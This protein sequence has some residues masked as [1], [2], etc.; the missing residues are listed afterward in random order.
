MKDLLVGSTGFVGENLKMAHKFGAFCHS[1]DVY[2]YYGMEPDLCV[3][4]GVPSAMY[5]AN[6]DPDADMAVIKQA[7][8]NIRKI[9]PKKLILISTVAVYSTHKGKD[10]NSEEVLNDMSVYGYNRALL[11]KWVRADFPEAMIVRLPALYGEGLRKNF[12]YDLHT[13]IPSMLRSDKYESLSEGNE[14]IRTSYISMD[15]GF[16]KLTDGADKKGLR[17]FFEDNDFNA[18]SFTDSRSRYQFYNLGRLWRDICKI[19]EEDIKLVNL[20]TPPI[21]ARELYQYITGKFNWKNLLKS[22]YDYDIKSIHAEIFGGSDG[23]ICSV[24]EE[25]RNI[26]SF[27]KAWKAKDE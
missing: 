5:L 23:Y 7:L 19:I 25:I 17:L 16:Y 12:L 21:S 3:Y 26:D 13:I 1:V 8:D 10:E 18:L 4:A 15:N 14:F 24:D 2:D 9:R 6:S 20:V 11:E 27:M 22:Y